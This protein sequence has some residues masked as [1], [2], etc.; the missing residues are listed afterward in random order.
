MRNEATHV[1]DYALNRDCALKCISD[2][3]LRDISVH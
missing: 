1:K 3:A 2:D